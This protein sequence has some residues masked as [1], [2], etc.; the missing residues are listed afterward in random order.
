MDPLLVPPFS[1]GPDQNINHFLAELDDFFTAREIVADNLR[2]CNARLLLRGA[3]HAWAIARVFD[4]YGDFT[5]R[6]R[7]EFPPDEMH[8]FVRL[9]TVQQRPNETVRDY[10]WRTSQLSA[11]CQFVPEALVVRAFLDG[12]HPR[13]RQDCYASA[14]ATLAD[15]LRVSKWLEESWRLQQAAQRGPVADQWVDCREPEP[16]RPAQRPHAHQQ[17]DRPP[18]RPAAPPPYAPQPARPPPFRPP[19]QQ[20]FHRRPEHPHAPA[21]APQELCVQTFQLQAPESTPLPPEPSHRHAHTSMSAA[22]EPDFEPVTPATAEDPATALV[23]AEHASLASAD[24]SISDPE[25]MSTLDALIAAATPALLNVFSAMEAWLPTPSAP[26]L[27]TASP[28]LGSCGLS[29]MQDGRK[30]AGDS[31]PKPPATSTAAAPPCLEAQGL[32]QHDEPS[33]SS[34][35]VMPTPQ[36]RQGVQ[37]DS[38]HPLQDPTDAFFDISQYSSPQHVDVASDLDTADGDAL[39]CQSF[40]GMEA[41]ACLGTSPSPMAA[42]GSCGRLMMQDGRKSA[43]DSI[44]MPLA[45]STALTPPCLEAAASLPQHDEALRPPSLPTVM[46]ALLAPGDLQP[47]PVRDQLGAPAVAL[48]ATLQSS[49][50]EHAAATSTTSGSPSA[51]PLPSNDSPAG[52]TPDTPSG[53]VPALLHGACGLPMV[54]DGRKAAGDYIPMSSAS[55]TAAA[56]ITAADPTCLEARA[57]LPQ[58]DEAW[59]PPPLSPLTV[60]PASHVCDGVRP[61]PMQP[62]PMHELQGD[63]ADTLLAIKQYSGAVAPTSSFTPDVMELPAVKR[64]FPGTNAVPDVSTPCSAPQQGACASLLVQDGR[65]AAGDSIPLFGF[66]PASSAAQRPRHA[67][68]SYLNI[69]TTLPT[70]PLRCSLPKQSTTEP[71]AVSKKRQLAELTHKLLEAKKRKRALDSL[72]EGKAAQRMSPGEA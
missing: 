19:Q 63:L 46:P 32:P 59:T 67:A 16:I 22:P 64:S 17:R 34:P 12:L 69:P 8:A 5:T 44:P 55:T 40:V 23:P 29:L 2:I 10:H 61:E 4:S 11:A 52:V 21:L 36:V 13:L 58:H 57:S 70:P 1:A 50:P 56:S 48:L 66:L 65:K 60:M 25:T 38:V 3:P 20:H 37:P 43:G 54:Q 9:Q 15:A 42:H 39:T 28:A 53:V 24:T 7:A 6:L 33:P 31:I 49:S 51:V 30:A 18:P 41:A 27:W 71:P 35:T 45:T 26:L 62:E 72:L 68:A 47:Q 14:P